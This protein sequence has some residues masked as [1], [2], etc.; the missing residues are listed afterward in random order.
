[1]AMIQ[2]TLNGTVVDMTQVAKAIEDGDLL[3]TFAA[4]ESALANVSGVSATAAGAIR[5]R[6]MNSG[7]LPTEKEIN[8]LL[9]NAEFTPNKSVIHP[10]F[11]T[12]EKHIPKCPTCGSTSLTKI[13]A[14]GRAVDGFFF[15]QL[16]VEGRAQWRC[17]SC[18][19]MW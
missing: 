18:G 2:Y 8:L 1:M 10:N 16:S 17:E 4:L 14:L 15:G 11:P 3:D 19:Y 7:A 5:K 12:P 13:G 6:I 9:N